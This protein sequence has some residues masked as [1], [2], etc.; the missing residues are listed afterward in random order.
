M[1]E[2]VSYKILPSHFQSSFD[3]NGTP[4]S[5]GILLNNKKSGLVTDLNNL[6]NPR[7]I[8]T[9]DIP[10]NS[11]VDY[12]TVYGLINQGVNNNDDATN[13]KIRVFEKFIDSDKHNLVGKGHIN[14]SIKTD[15]I[16]NNKNYLLIE[17]DGLDTVVTGGKILFARF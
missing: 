3:D 1:N 15:V 14:S 5:L 11:R 4:K 9:C 10:L 6:D 8:A 13:V 12:V 2:Y 17:L 7:M 16:S